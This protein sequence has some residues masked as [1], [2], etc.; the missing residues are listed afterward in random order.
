MEL[1]ALKKLSNGVKPGERFKE[2]NQKIAHILLTIG[3]A[4]VADEPQAVPRRRRG[5]PR[6]AS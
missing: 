3:V 6:K 4:K 2:R 1:I 5:R